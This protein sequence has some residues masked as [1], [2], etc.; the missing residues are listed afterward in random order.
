[1]ALRAALWAVSAVGWFVWAAAWTALGVCKTVAVVL[2]WAV[3]R[4]RVRTQPWEAFEYGSV[5]EELRFARRR[6]S[7]VNMSV[8]ATRP[9]MVLALALTAGASLVLGRMIS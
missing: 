9:A 1:M 7:H 2:S 8:V 3:A 5:D 6:G 4:V